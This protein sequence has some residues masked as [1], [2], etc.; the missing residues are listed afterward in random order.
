MRLSMS[1]I[2]RGASI[3]GLAVRRLHP[4]VVVGNA[5]LFAAETAAVAATVLFLGQITTTGGA[6]ARFI[7]QV[8]GWLW[9]T[10]CYSSLVGVIAEGRHSRGREV[11]VQTRQKGP[12]S[13][14][15]PRTRRTGCPGVTRAELSNGCRLTLSDQGS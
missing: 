2:H 1:S 4:R 8:A 11:C 3:A 14:C 15:A 10:V 9:F 7:G 6:E 5:V 13:G 12:S